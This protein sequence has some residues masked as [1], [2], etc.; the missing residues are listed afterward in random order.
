MRILK[1]WF[2]DLSNGRL[3]TPKEIG[4]AARRDRAY[5]DGGSYSAFQAFFGRNDVQYSY[6][7]S[8]RLHFKSFF[9]SQA[10][11]KQWERAD[12]QHT[13]PRIQLFTGHLLIALQKLGMPFYAHSAFR[14]EAEQAKAFN[15]GHSKLVWP[16]APHCQGKAVDIVHSRFHWDMTTDEWLL[17]GRIAHDVHASLMADTPKEKRWALVWGGNWKKPGQ[18]LGWDPAHFEI[19]GWRNVISRPVAGPPLRL[20]PRGLISRV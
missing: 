10:H 6:E 15:S 4:A 19:A 8:R 12:W 17:V 7:A 11:L 20:T 18:L 16:V 9:Y 14:S 13:D 2:Q 3:K 5:D 1:Q